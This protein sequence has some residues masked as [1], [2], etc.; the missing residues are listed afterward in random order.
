MTF[1]ENCIPYTDGSTIT[2][3]DGTGNTD[4]ETIIFSAT[5]E[6]S[7]KTIKSVH[8]N[9]HGEPTGMGWTY[10]SIG[11]DRV[12][13]KPNGRNSFIAGPMSIRKLPSDE[14]TRRRLIS[15][16]VWLCA[17]A[18]SGPLYAAL[19]RKRR[20]NEEKTSNQAWLRLPPTPD[21]PNASRVVWLR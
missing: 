20:T 4:I 8:T 15:G 3:Q 14:I 17:S 13:V 6:F 19:I 1:R 16:V 7:T 2:W 12:Q 18:A 11:P 5:G 21:L 10:S 9:G